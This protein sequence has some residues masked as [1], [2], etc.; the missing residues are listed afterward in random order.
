[1]LRLEGERR[2]EPSLY[3]AEWAYLPC[4]NDLGKSSKTVAYVPMPEASGGMKIAYVGGSCEN[5]AEWNKVYSERG[6]CYELTVDYIPGKYR[7]LFIEVNNGEPIRIDRLRETAE[8]RSVASI[9]VPVRLKAG[10]NTV[11]MGSPY[12]WAPDIDCFQLK[13]IGD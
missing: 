12:C 7:R 4:F 13:R 11:R 9:T 3:E 1:M 2:I 8:G 5:Y 6:G 10:Y